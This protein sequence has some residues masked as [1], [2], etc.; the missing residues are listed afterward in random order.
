VKEKDKV[1]LRTIVLF[2]FGGAI[3]AGVIFAVIKISMYA[4][5]RQN[6]YNNTPALSKN[7]PFAPVNEDERTD[8]KKAIRAIYVDTRHTMQGYITAANRDF[9]RILDNLVFPDFLTDKSSAWKFNYGAL[10][11]Q[12][13]PYTKDDKGNYSFVTADNSTLNSVPLM[14]HVFDE[15]RVQLDDND[16]ELVLIFT[17]EWGLYLESGPLVHSPQWTLFTEAWDNLRGENGVS[18]F[19]FPLKFEGALPDLAKGNG[20]RPLYLLVV[21]KKEVVFAE[22]KRIAELLEN[23]TANGIEWNYISN[24]PFVLK[25]EEEPFFSSEKSSNVQLAKD[26]LYRD[27]HGS[28]LQIAPQAES[29]TLQYEYKKGFPWDL[30]VVEPS[31]VTPVV[32]GGEDEEVPLHRIIYGVKQKEGEPVLQSYTEWYDVQSDAFSTDMPAPEVTVDLEGIT[33]VLGRELQ[34]LLA[35]GKRYILTINIMPEAVKPTSW[36]PQYNTDKWYRN[37]GNQAEKT[38][39]LTALFSEKQF[40]PQLCQTDPIYIGLEAIGE[41]VNEEFVK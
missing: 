23:E 19:V 2:I 17:N 8:P 20:S 16:R 27:G 10:N 31:I 29:V 1:K 26:S 14:T 25:G 5:Q 12:I 38:Y 32:F 9:T 4:I 18:L 40:V 13:I 30:A 41:A 37:N 24:V 39:G 28:Y 11:Q 22:T 36:L 33:V 15:A 35:N 6:E 34:S 21:G 7:S 3:C